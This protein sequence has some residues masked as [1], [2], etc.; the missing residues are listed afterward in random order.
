MDKSDLGTT[1][2]S[3][4]SH[5]LTPA[6]APVTRLTPVTVI[7]RVPAEISPGADGMME[8]GV[9][10]G[11]DCVGRETLTGSGSTWRPGEVAAC[12]RDWKVSTKCRGSVAEQGRVFGQFGV[13]TFLPSEILKWLS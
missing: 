4:I 12:G 8:A 3:Q 6:P 7:H 1:G 2:L 13:L 10:V 5:I 11:V 9:R